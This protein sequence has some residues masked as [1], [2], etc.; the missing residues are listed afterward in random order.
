MKI[1]EPVTQNEVKLSE[2]SVITSTTDLKGAITSINDE[3]VQISGFSEAEIIGKN[4]NLVRHPDMPAVAFQDLWDNVKKS[5]P[6]LGIVKNRCKNGDFYWV[7]AYVAALV[8]NGS[9]IGYQS[10]RKKASEIEIQRA[11]KL[12]ADITNNKKPRIKSLGLAQTFIAM[13]I[14]C[15]GTVGIGYYYSLSENQPLYAYAGLVCG[16]MIGLLISQTI[17]RPIKLAAENARQLIH[18]PL[19]QY[20]LTGQANEFGQIMLSMELQQNKLSTL[21]YRTTHASNHL[22][23]VAN[24]TTN[25]VDSIMTSINQEHVEIDQVATAINEMTSTVEEV[26]KNITDTASAAQEAKAEVKIIN[27]RIS[28]TIGFISTLENDMQGSAEVIHRLAENS[29]NIGA[30]L[31]V[32]QNIA[33]QTNLLALNAAIEAARAGEAGR[34]FAVVADEVRILATRTAEST[35]EIEKIITQI[36]GAA[37]DAVGAIDVA[38][39]HAEDT[40]DC[41]ENT[42]ESIVTVTQA[43]DRID[44][45]SNQIA[46]A[47]E[48]QNLVSQEINQSIHSISDSV[49]NT[50][51]NAE[52]TAET[53][54]S[55][56]EL[57]SELKKVIQQSG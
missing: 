15:C 19:A 12:Y 2:D 8:E 53:A 55:F 27:H 20:A 46:S 38:K 13:I 42:A 1:N 25:S 31:D 35:Q 23:N 14:M 37:K 44:A 54:L 22:E 4:H 21:R 26:S 43:V 48:E 6:W 28:E 17:I 57:S 50:A 29:Q 39:K 18:N 7:K 47:A 56:A 9:T 34:G 49:R 16:A 32:I 45:M 52:K 24:N 3:F 36:Q 51:K 40:A 10:V 33:E 11:K 5:N 41:I 30:V